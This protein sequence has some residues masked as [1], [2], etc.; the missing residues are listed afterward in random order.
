MPDAVAGALVLGNE[1][2]GRV[3]ELAAAWIRLTPEGD[4]HASS[5]A[6]VEAMEMSSGLEAVVRTV[7]SA[8]TALAQVR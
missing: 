2:T 1:I 6:E 8:Y 3:T 5:V 4:V 7:D